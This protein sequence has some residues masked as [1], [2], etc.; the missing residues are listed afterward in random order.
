MDEGILFETDPQR[1]RQARRLVAA[2]VGPRELDKYRPQLRAHVVSFLG[3]VL[4]NPREYGQ[5]IRE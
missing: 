2:C 4:E 1:L 5:H 3:R